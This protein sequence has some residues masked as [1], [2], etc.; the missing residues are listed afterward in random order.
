MTS[1]LSDPTGET[2][3]TTTVPSV[4]V[5]N[6]PSPNAKRD[7]TLAGVLLLLAVVAGIVAALAIVKSVEDDSAWWAAL[8]GAAVVVALSALGGA[9]LLVWNWLRPATGAASDLVEGG[10][11]SGWS[12]IIGVFFL[13]AIIAGILAA[14]SI[15]KAIDTCTS[16]EAGSA[17]TDYNPWWTALAGAMVV[18]GLIARRGSSAGSAPWPPRLDGPERGRR[19]TP[20]GGGACHGIGRHRHDWRL[21]LLRHRPS[22]RVRLETV[23]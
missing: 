6:R 19:H 13:L 9:A 4:V 14:V 5:V 17:C 21:P 7:L 16:P 2:T 10:R 20:G 3:T 12:S 23:E 8:A 22:I 11:K 1:P 15:A 18:L